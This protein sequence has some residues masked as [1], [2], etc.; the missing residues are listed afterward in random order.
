MKRWICLLLA[1]ALCLLPACG[2]KTQG[3]GVV[4]GEASVL[5]SGKALSGEEQVVDTLK[6]AYN[7][8]DS[9]EPYRL[10]S[11]M[12]ANLVPLIYEPLV[13]LDTSYV[14]QNIL[15]AQV[16]VEG[17]TCVVTL[18]P[19]AVFSDGSRVTPEDVLYSVQQVRAGGNVY[20]GL[21]AGVEKAEV[22]EDGAVVFTLTE[23]N[24]FFANLLTFPIV[25]AENPSLGSG[26][27]VVA[28]N[29]EAK[30]LTANP[31]WGGKAGRI[32]TVQLV[33]Q[34]DKDTLIYSLKLGTIN[35]AYADQTGNESLS[36][37]VSTQEVPLNQLVYLGM[38]AGGELLSNA[39]VRSAVHLALDRD[40]LANGVYG[41]RAAVAYT[42]FNPRAREICPQ[43]FTVEHDMKAA[44]ELMASVGYA[45]RDSEGYYVTEKGRLRLRLVV[46]VDNASRTQAA[47]AIARSLRELGIEVTVEGKLFE[48]YKATLASR[49]FDL[50]LGTTRL[51]DDMDIGFLLSPKGSLG[52]GT[53]ETPE[54]TAAH[55]Q[56]RAGAITPQEFVDVF[57]TYTPFVPLMYRSAMVAF[58]RGAYFDAVATEHDIFYNIENW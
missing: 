9:L 50:Y 53:V 38:N 35:Y 26:R 34:L 28:G 10:Y 41:S 36:L 5:D 56:L 25:K 1:A 6:V 2:A 44:Q 16:R 39:T 47:E 32:K 3:Q 21:L 13:R 7:N 49:D 58:S 43:G 24:V 37:G 52:Y 40:A 20:R 29:A 14:P 46:N 4:T 17:L 27:Y 30:Y 55:Q 18:R 54:L 31:R 11:T 23:P 8:A 51:Y 19:D 12:N 48:E 15:A 22:R 42:P 57:Y 45:Q 33:N